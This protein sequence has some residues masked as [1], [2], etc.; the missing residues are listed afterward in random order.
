MPA[1]H[2]TGWHLHSAAIL[3]VVIKYDS[4]L[5]SILTWKGIQINKAFSVQQES[6][7]FHFHYSESLTL[8]KYQC[9]RIFFDLT[10][11]APDEKLNIYFKAAIFY[12][13]AGI[14]T[15]STYKTSKYQGGRLSVSFK[16]PIFKGKYPSQITTQYIYKTTQIL[17]HIL[18]LNN[19][20]ILPITVKPTSAHFLM[21]K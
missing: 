11:F 5:A 14:K 1:G 15:A 20:H 3:F 12:V 18:F 4:L 10:W 7:P 16:K 19:I 8:M 6:S 17:R 21:A 2:M 9:N 13:L